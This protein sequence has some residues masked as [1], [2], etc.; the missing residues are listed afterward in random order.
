MKFNI[1]IIRSIFSS[2]IL[3]GLL[4]SA[5]GD[6]HHFFPPYPKN[7]PTG[8]ISGKI[9]P[10]DSGILI[11]ARQREDVYGGIAGIDSTTGKFTINKPPS[12]TYDLMLM[13]IG[14]PYYNVIGQQLDSNYLG[15]KLTQRDKDIIQILI[16]TF[17][18]EQDKA[19]V[20][21]NL[22]ILS[23]SK[24]LAKNFKDKEK[25]LSKIQKWM[26][27]PN[28]EPLKVTSKRKIWLIG[29]NQNKAYVICNRV[30]EFEGNNKIKLMER[31][32]QFGI[33]KL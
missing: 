21:R 9:S 24:L 7:T 30:R 20:R 4:A 5:R 29:G 27:Q 6:E 25:Y 3:L 28:Y 2:I 16:S 14:K 11:L 23:D 18:E 13:C 33:I 32:L 12:G 15:D 1:K 8:A 17:S 10:L 22:T 26:N 19:Y 31:I